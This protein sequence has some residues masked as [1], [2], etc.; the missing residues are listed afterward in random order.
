MGEEELG[1]IRTLNKKSL[2]K[3]LTIPYGKIE[4]YG[5]VIVE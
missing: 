5:R 1:K 2:N 3:C 4:E